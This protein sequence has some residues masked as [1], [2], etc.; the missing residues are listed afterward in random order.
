[1]PGPFSHWGEGNRRSLES[2]WGLT[3]AHPRKRP[4]P[5]G[6][7]VP[8]LELKGLCGPLSQK[9]RHR[10]YSRGFWAQGNFFLWSRSQVPSWALRVTQGPGDWHKPPSLGPQDHS[11]REPELRVPPPIP[12]GKPNRTHSEARRQR[13]APLQA[14]PYPRC[15]L[16]GQTQPALD[17]CFA[18]SV[19]KC[20]LGKE[21]A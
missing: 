9:S 6:T 11:H 19:T 5:N 7:L 8:G 1:M 21:K 14:L 3:H 2:S 16:R 4:T 15:R 13:E 17:A 20:R 10:P 18:P 12:T